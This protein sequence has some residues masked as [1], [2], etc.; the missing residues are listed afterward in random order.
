MGQ[1]FYY[2][3]ATLSQRQNPVNACVMQSNAC[4]FESERT[5]HS[6]ILAKYNNER[7]DPF[8]FCDLSFNIG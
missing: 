3:I 8:S 2:E 7:P 6:D 5:G 1:V 4:E